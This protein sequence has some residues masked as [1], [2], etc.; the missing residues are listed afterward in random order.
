[1]TLFLIKLTKFEKTG[2]I[3]EFFMPLGNLKIE[4]HSKLE[5][6][7]VFFTFALM[8]FESGICFPFNK[9]NE[10]KLEINQKSNRGKFEREQI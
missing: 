4:F 6:A 3:V 10:V 9:G 8:L 1:M 7:H 2:S 5:V